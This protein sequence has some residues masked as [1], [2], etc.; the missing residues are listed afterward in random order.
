MNP[1]ELAFTVGDMH[2]PHTWGMKSP[3]SEYAQTWHLW[4]LSPCHGHRNY[5]LDPVCSNPQDSTREM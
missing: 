3:V 1:E 4:R 2:G 5:P